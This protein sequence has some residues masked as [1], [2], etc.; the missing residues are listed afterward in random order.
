MKGVEDEW[1]T[2]LMH[3]DDP[4]VALC[5][6]RQMKGRWRPGRQNRPHALMRGERRTAPWDG[7][8]EQARQQTSQITLGVSFSALL[9][10]IQRQRLQEPQDDGRRL[11]RYVSHTDKVWQTR[12]QR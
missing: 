1:R 8:G 11:V 3:A 2:Q 7:S 10:P 5:A 4:V 6:L 9:Q 12:G